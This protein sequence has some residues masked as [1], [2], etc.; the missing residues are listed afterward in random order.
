MKIIQVFIVS[1][2]LLSC[3]DTGLSVIE[4]NPAGPII[5]LQIGNTW[6]YEFSQY[7]T[8]GT[9]I[10]AVYD[11][12]ALAIDTVLDNRVWFFW[13]QPEM[14]IANY[15]DG[16]WIRSLEIGFSLY[17][18]LMYK[19]PAEVGDLWT[20]D[21]FST[22]HMQLTSINE[23]TEVPAGR[24]SCHVYDFGSTTGVVHIVPGIGMVFSEMFNFVPSGKSYRYVHRLLSYSLQ[25]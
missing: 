17:P 14:Y 23:V 10:S 24:F 8:L 15:S 25:S 6:I 12:V 16:A 4:G 20:F 7:D 5:P 18:S 22:F 9:L 1:L 21:G 11:T 13:A 2:V 3:N 19:Y